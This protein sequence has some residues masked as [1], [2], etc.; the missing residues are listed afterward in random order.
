MNNVIITLIGFSLVMLVLV[1][2]LI[3]III[4]NKKKYDKLEDAHNSDLKTIE[5]YK[6]YLEQY[7]KITEEKENAIEKI[8]EAKTDEEILAA[9]N[10]TAILSNNDRVRNDKENDK[11]AAKTTKKRTSGNKKS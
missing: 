2:V 6:R 10:S 7:Q 9:V 8:K 1:A 4:N 3:K 5:Y 11:P